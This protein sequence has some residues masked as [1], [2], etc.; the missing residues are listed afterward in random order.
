MLWH[1]A[2]KEDAGHH[3]LASGDT[4]CLDEFTYEGHNLPL[5]I[6]SVCSKGSI[7]RVKAFHHRPFHL[8]TKQKR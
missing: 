2:S 7:T 1:K 8:S 6:N 4:S 5:T 3:W